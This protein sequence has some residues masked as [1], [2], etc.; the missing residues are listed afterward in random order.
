DAT[1]ADELWLLEHPPV[2]T[3]GLAGK[4][5]HVLDAGAVPVLRCDRG[6]QVTYHGPGQVVLYTLLDLQRAGLGVK[7]LVD[8]LEQAVIDLLAECGV[9]A[10]RRAGAPG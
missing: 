3:L 8:T 2:F 10:E 7:R 1:T 6:G 9:A 4:P 5:E